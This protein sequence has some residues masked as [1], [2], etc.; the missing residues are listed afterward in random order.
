MQICEG[1]ASLEAAFA[2]TL[3]PRCSYFNMLLNIF[4]ALYSEWTTLKS[5]NSPK[6]SENTKLWLDTVS[7]SNE[8]PPCLFNQALF[9]TTSPT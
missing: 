9:S 4:V 6:T 3:L 1:G 2:E 7:P 8:D 5:K